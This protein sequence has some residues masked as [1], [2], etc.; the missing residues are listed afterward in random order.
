MAYPKRTYTA[1]IEDVTY[2]DMNRIEEGI[3]Q[4]DKNKVDKV[5]GKGLSANDYTTTEKN[6]LAGIA[7]GANNYVHPTT[8]DASII[9]ESATKRFVTDVE[10]STWN[11][12]ETIV[13]SQ[14]KADA[15]LTS[16]KEYADGKVKFNGAQTNV[17]FIRNNLVQDGLINNNTIDTSADFL[18]MY[19]AFCD[20]ITT[21]ADLIKCGATTLGGFQLVMLAGGTVR[22]YITDGVSYKSIKSVGSM[23]IGKKY[24]IILSKVGKTFTIRINNDVYI[25]DY[26]DMKDYIGVV[27]VRN[28][29]SVIISNFLLYNRIL[30]P[31]EI[32]HNFSVLSN[33][34]SIN[35]INDYAISTDTDHVQD[36]TGRVQ[37]TINRV[38]YKNMCKEFTS[39]GEAISVNNGMDGYVLSGKIEGQTV[40]NL[41]PTIKKEN[42]KDTTN[43]A[44]SVDG[45]NMKIT[46]TCDGLNVTNPDISNIYKN[47][48]P[49]K[50]YILKYWIYENSLSS[51]FE[52]N[53]GGSAIGT[54]TPTINITQ[55][56]TGVKEIEVTSKSDL[57]NATSL[58]RTYTPSTLIGKVV[59]SVAL[60]EVGSKTSDKI[61][62][63]GLNSTQATIYNNQLKYS[64]YSSLDDKLAGRVLD[65]GGIEG[66]RN[67]FEIKEDGSG[68]Y[69]QNGKYIVIDGTDKIGLT[70]VGS[71]TPWD[72]T[73]TNVW[74]NNVFISDWKIGQTTFLAD[75]YKTATESNRDLNVE[76]VHCHTSNNGLYIQIARSNMIDGSISS[77]KT[78]LQ[79]NPI[80]VIYQLATPIVTHIP[81]EIMPTILTQLQN[82]FKVDSA[83][84]PYKT[85]IQMPINRVADLETRLAQLEKVITSTS[86]VSL[87]SNYVDDEYNKNQNTESEMI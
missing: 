6:K 67:T 71:N 46:I 69:T 13:G 22:L 62:P 59:Y 36:R 81:K 20:N 86:N 4:A 80:K 47:I 37:D 39:N 60:F 35:K 87:L 11:A 82:D 70:Y 57:T 43:S 78:Y 24:N 61:V 54:F 16:A 23:E 79:T 17:N 14:A 34:Q 15:A 49:N 2:E 12:K 65:L 58:I 76:M 1:G 56:F 7:T 53:A 84:A 19:S 64:F 77:F 27:A 9:T 72:T 74:H 28:F 63:F 45:L 3:Y 48:E 25:A 75:K 52:L 30:A 29:S 68:V 21:T 10:K 33:S 44:I 40:K 18:V 5:D 50:K 38:F 51:S 55:G 73:N 42:V 83:V 26:T 66:A 41:C 31:Q 32:Q 8:H 85:T